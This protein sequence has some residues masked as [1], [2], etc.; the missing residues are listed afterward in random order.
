MGD[1]ETIG[2]NEVREFQQYWSIERLRNLTLEEY[3]NLN[4]ENSLT[5]WLESKTE[6]AGSI[7]GGGQ[8]ECGG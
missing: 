3:T 5:Y 2:L 4:K 6:H 8:G 7:W 1:T